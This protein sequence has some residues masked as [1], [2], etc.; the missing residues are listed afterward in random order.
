VTWTLS[1]EGLQLRVSALWVMLEAA[2]PLGVEGACVSGE[3]AGGGGV[4]GGGG[5]GGEGAHALVCTY[6]RASEERFP[7]AST[8]STA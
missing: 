2:S 1:V 3:G 8:A 4:V 5:G 7:A 6:A